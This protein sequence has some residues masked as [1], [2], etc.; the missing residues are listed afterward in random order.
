MKPVRTLEAVPNKP[1]T[2]HRS[3]RVPD[4]EWADLD[5]AASS[6]GADR[7]KVINQLIR[8]YLQRPGADL[9]E[10]PSRLRRVRA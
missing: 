2:Q 8:W 1:R 7:A 4:E 5:M 3:V 9:P 6:V 10:R